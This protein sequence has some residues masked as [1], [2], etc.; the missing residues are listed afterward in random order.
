MFAGSDK[1]IRGYQI[2]QKVINFEYNRIQAMNFTKV[3]KRHRANSDEKT[4]SKDSK[5]VKT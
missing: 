1:H 2:N 3:V 5:Y 4:T